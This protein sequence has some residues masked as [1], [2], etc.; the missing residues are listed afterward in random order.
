MDA[1]F[2]TT[3]QYLISTF[4]NSMLQVFSVEMGA[5]MAQ[6]ATYEVASKMVGPQARINCVPFNPRFAMLSTG[7]M[8]TCF[9][10][11]NME[12]E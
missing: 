1:C 7:S 6:L 8:Q 4:P 5:Q 10:L 12:K 9:W 11:P 2:T 3:S